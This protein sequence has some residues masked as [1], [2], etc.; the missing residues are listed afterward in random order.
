MGKWWH[1]LASIGLAAVGVVVPVVQGAVASHPA[2]A[3]VLA[4]SW[5]VLGAVLK[6]PIDGTK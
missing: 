4:A 3:A 5:G 2:I 6:S 1:V